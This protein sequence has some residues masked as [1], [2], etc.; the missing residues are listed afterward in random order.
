[1]RERQDLPR[2]VRTI[3]HTWIELP[4]GC[5]LAARMWLPEDAGADP[6]P[7]VLDA[8]PYRKGDGTEARDATRYPYIAGHGYACVRLDL[9]GSGDSEGLI[10]DEYSAQEQ[11][12]ID[13]VIAWLAAQQW[14]DGG[15]AMIGV[16]WGG[17]AALQA[18]ARA[19]A[20]L[21]AI[22]AIHATDDRY[23][24]DVHYIGGCVLATDMV[25]WS[26]C[27]SAYV[28]QPPDPA[29]VGDGWR[30][31]WR[32][33]LEAMEPWVATWLSH[34]RR[35]D[36]WRAGSVCEDY[37]RISCP[38]LAVGG[39]VDGYRDM[40][41]RVAE[42]VR[43]PVRGLIGP[44]GH[45][46]PERG[47][48][49]PAIGF[50]Q[51]V[52][53]F[54]DC[55]MKGAE[56]GFLDEPLLVSYMQEPRAPGADGRERAGR[57]VADPAWPSPNVRTRA[58]ALGDGTLGRVAAARRTVRGLGLTG[59]EAGVWCGDGGPADL[60][61]DQRPED[62]ASLCW[63]SAPLP[64]RLELLGSAAAVLEL[65]SD[66]PLALVV[67]RLCDVA[68]DGGSALI[69]RGLLNLTHR[70]GHDRVDPLVPGE[71]VAVRVPMQSTAY[72]V[73]AGHSL[74]LAV[75]PTYW[76]WAWPSPEPVSLTVISG[77]ESRLELPV[78]TPSPAD[79]GLRPFG[80]PE[81][82]P[83]LAERALAT[84]RTGRTARRDLAAGAA[85]LEYAWIDSSSLIVPSATE[86]GERNVARYRLV[87]GDP[88]SAEARCEVAVELARG[89]WR[90][91]VEVRSIMRCDADHFHLDTEL[92][93]YEGAAPFHSCRWSHAI[94]RDG[95]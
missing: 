93:A 4:D 88:L 1:M 5:R 41:L 84:G 92:E 82:A 17:F 39:W 13:D 9:R 16:S 23:A 95:G 94:A 21:R 60:P 66:R 7:A 69:A 74:R 20:A 19:P 2:A 59:S 61:G 10:D 68:P 22:V 49:G 32:A 55:T 46:W 85:E 3:D 77:G 14:C 37:D 86:L 42:H 51:E 48:P 15:V 34:Q 11:R 43:A 36:Y 65:E 50:L 12:D 45:S 75:S 8:V 25:H 56:N 58:L 27:M 83:G 73:P 24:D 90:T 40:V 6:V 44:W 70:L 64:E 31:A 76:P 57:W 63:D 80:A 38:V 29:V 35:D 33:R 89:S 52:V 47:A 81:C 91:S 78:R 18:A 62:G 53:R 72:A 87:E 71:P 67:V 79:A 26:A 30:A 28:G 54:F